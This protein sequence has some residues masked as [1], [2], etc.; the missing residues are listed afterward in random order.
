MLTA[1]NKLRQRNS[2]MATIFYW[3]VFAMFGAVLLMTLM[4][5]VFAED[6]FD[7]AK[8]ML[9]SVYGKI[10]A[11][12]TVV[13]V[14]CA[15]IALLIRMFSRN[16]RAI[17]SANDWLK[18]IV[19]SWLAI[20]SLTFIINLLSDLSGNSRVDSSVLMIGSNLF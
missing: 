7:K 6:I 14:L 4:S 3:S 10:H 2:N 16:Q 5:P 19:I 17:E 15:T 9:D 18:R 1:S 20:N 11:M 8:T 12:T 13:A